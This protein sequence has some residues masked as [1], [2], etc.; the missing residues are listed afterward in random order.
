MRESLGRTSENLGMTRDETDNLATSLSN[1]TFPLDDATATMSSLSEQGIESRDDMEEVATAMDSVADA[2]GTSAETVANSMGPAL[3]AFGEDLTDAE[4]HMDTFTFVANNTTMDVDEFGG[5]I[6][7][8]APDLQEMGLSLDETAQMMAALEEKGITGRQAIQ[9]IRQATN[10]AEGDQQAF[11]EELGLTESEIAAQSDALENAKGSTKAHAEA[12]NES[13]TP[14]DSLRSAFEDAKLQAS[15]LIGPVSAAAPAMQAAGIAAMTL[16]TV[17]TSA[18][19]PSLSGVLAALTPLLPVLLPLIAAV[20][21]FALAWQHDFMGVRAIVEDF[22]E[23]AHR[24]SA[25]S[26]SGSV[27]SRT[28][29]TQPSPAISHRHCGMPKPSS[30]TRSA[31]SARGFERVRSRCFATPPERSSTAQFRRSIRSKRRLPR[32]SVT[33]F[34]QLSRGC[35]RTDRRSSGRGSK[36][37]PTPRKT[38]SNR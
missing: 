12:A 21:A 22:A 24:P 26:K 35:G 15:G 36:R 13:L 31:G 20:G 29:P 27:A 37:L 9:E 28:S 7:R 1:A 5:A 17:N 25:P 19:I 34:K 11:K 23:A 32:R 4:E 30:T 3:S 8:M 14:M 18:L 33:R 10:E 38:S 2:T 16:S 6:E